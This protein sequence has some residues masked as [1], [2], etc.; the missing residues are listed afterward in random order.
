MNR[1]EI[2]DFLWAKTT[3]YR[4][5]MLTAHETITEIED[6][7]ENEEGWEEVKP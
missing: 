1:Q 3:G 2:L 4:S 5:S 6:M 7:C